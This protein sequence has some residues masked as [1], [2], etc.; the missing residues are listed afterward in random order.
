MGGLQSAQIRVKWLCNS[1]QASNYGWR[2]ASIRRWKPGKQQ[3]AES[4]NG[5]K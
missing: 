2:H 1:G 4:M 3:V 5:W